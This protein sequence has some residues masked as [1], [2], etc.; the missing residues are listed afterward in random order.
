MNQPKR[1]LWVLDETVFEHPKHMLRVRNRK[2]IAILS[3]K[4]L[5]N[6]PYGFYPFL[7]GKLI[8]VCAPLAAKAPIFMWGA[9]IELIILPWTHKSFYWF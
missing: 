4:K 7:F 9:K 8:S 6:W 1:M 2:I 5:L 3:K